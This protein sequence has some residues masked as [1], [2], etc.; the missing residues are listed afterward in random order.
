M[1]ILILALIAKAATPPATSASHLPD[2]VSQTLTMHYGEWQ[3]ATLSE[4]TRLLLPK[5]VDGNVVKGDF[6]GD[7]HPD[8]AVQIVTGVGAGRV[9][10]VVVLLRRGAAYVPFSIHDSQP[11]D[12]SYLILA[13][14]GE[15]RLDLDADENG[16]KKIRLP[17]DA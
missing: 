3:F 11:I 12:Y 14:K 4:D 15:R 16:E 2:A 7:K 6:D 5:N 17:T 13:R 9:E 10:R 1:F 8:Y